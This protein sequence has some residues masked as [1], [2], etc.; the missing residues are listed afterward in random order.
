MP[1]NNEPI[2]E[3]AEPT[4]ESS[5]TELE[6]TVVEEPT[7]PKYYEEGWHE[8]VMSQFLESEL[9]NEHPTCD[10][11]RRVTEKLIGPIVER[12]ITHVIPLKGFGDNDTG[13]VAVKVTVAPRNFVE[14]ERQVIIEE[15]IADI[16][17][18]NTE[19]KFLI[20]PLATTESRAVARALRKILR[21]RKVIAAEET[22]D[23]N[24][25]KLKE[26]ITWEPDD[27]ISDEQVNAIDIICSRLNINVMQYINCGKRQ[28]DD[29]HSITKSKAAIIISH[30]NKIQQSVVDK[31]RTVGNYDKNWRN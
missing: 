26:L 15:S 14:F 3:I 7:I 1:T 2:L 13:A 31:P 18:Q 16:N 29:I 19:I 30:L 27:P 5:I 9:E 11:L 20:H 4:L 12:H 22:S 28:Y 21:L 17:K 24:E 6:N 10:G 25:E 8:Y 23:I